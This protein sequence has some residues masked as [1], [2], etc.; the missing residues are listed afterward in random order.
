MDFLI[1]AEAAFISPPPKKQPRATKSMP[2]DGAAKAGTKAR[3]NKV[4]VPKNKN[5]A[6]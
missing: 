4:A 1:E 3:P 2:I 5:V 6:A